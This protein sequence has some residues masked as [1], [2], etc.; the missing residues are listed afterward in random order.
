LYMAAPVHG[1]ACDTEYF[2]EGTDSQGDCLQCVGLN[3][4]VCYGAS[5]QIV[6]PS[7]QYNDASIGV[8][9]LGPKLQVQVYPTSDCSGTPNYVSGLSN[10]CQDCLQM[11]PTVSVT[12]D[13]NRFY[14]HGLW[15]W[16]SEKSVRFLDAVSTV[17]P[18][19]HE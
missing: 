2:C 1:Q 14:Y 18:Y 13:G 16:S 8:V 9:D 12:I 3:L 15:P 4:T 11:T 10:S 19:I 7:H 6:T 17:T 5:V